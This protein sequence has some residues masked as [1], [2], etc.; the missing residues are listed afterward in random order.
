[1]EQGDRHG[2]GVAA[3]LGA[4]ALSP[5]M[6]EAGSI[7]PSALASL[8]RARASGWGVRVRAHIRS[9]ATEKVE[10]SGA[11]ERSLGA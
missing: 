10:A 1:M 9:S 4:G 11:E 7:V 5:M 8:S 2:E 3:E 6:V